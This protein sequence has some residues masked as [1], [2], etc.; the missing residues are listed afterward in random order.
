[1]GCRYTLCPGISH[2]FLHASVP[3]IPH[4]DPDGSGVCECCPYT[5][6]PG[7]AHL[8]L[9][10]YFPYIPHPD[11]EGS[12]VC[13]CFRYILHPDPA[14]RGAHEC[15]LYIRSEEHTSE[16]QSRENLVSRL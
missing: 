2:L 13:E 6:R 12:G 16:L 15:C 11:P 5:L 8:F 10:G 4:P 3:Y 7:I 14:L 1:G 9:N